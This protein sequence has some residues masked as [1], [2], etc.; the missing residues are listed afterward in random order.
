[1]INQCDLSIVITKKLLSFQIKLL[2]S[3]GFIFLWIQKLLQFS[4]TSLRAI[5]LLE[6][7]F[8]ETRN[9]QWKNISIKKRCHIRRDLTNDIT[10]SP[11]TSHALFQNI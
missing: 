6:F 7:I 9:K 3:N 10:A 1:M 2:N 4:L 5:R 8:V 11:E